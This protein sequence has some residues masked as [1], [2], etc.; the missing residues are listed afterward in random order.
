LSERAI[1]GAGLVLW[2]KF[3]LI[4]FL[5]MFSASIERLAVEV[6]GVW[7]L[8]FGVSLTWNF[9]S[10]ICFRIMVFRLFSFFNM[11]ILLAGSI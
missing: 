1:N 7:Y 11:K 5:N 2:L 10:K 9:V 4:M 6:F 8:E 3:P